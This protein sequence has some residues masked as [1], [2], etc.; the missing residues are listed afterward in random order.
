MGHIPICWH[1]A[2]LLSALFVPSAICSRSWV[3]RMA[4]SM[5]DKLMPMLKAAGFSD[6]EGIPTRHRNFAFIRAH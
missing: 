6:V 4:E 2:T 1:T 5:V 3:T